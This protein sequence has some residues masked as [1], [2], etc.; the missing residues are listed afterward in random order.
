MARADTPSGAEL[1]TLVIARIREILEPNMALI[2][3]A[4]RFG[5]D[6]HADSLDLVEIL[7]SIESELRRR[8]LQVRLPDADVAAIRTVGDAVE[9]MT[10]HLRAADVSPARLPRTLPQP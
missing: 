8:G 7:E 2:D 6:L 5:E 10:L 1:Q 9:R 3:P 4:T